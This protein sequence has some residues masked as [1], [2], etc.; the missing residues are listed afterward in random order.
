MYSSSLYLFITTLG[1]IFHTTTPSRSQILRPHVHSPCSPPGLYS[2]TPFGQSTTSLFHS[3]PPYVPLWVRVLPVLPLSPSLGASYRTY[4]ISLTNRSS[5]DLSVLSDSPVG[6]PPSGRWAESRG[7]S[8]RRVPTE[9]P[10][11]D[12][13]DRSVFQPRR[14]TGG[15]GGTTPGGGRGTPVTLPL[16]PDQEVPTRPQTSPPAKPISRTSSRPST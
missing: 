9:V 4:P 7:R 15:E 1:F 6:T 8:T 3:T 11:R 13:N 2:Q 14:L 5:P 12:P 16:G 10:E